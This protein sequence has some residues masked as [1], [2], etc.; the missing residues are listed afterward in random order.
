VTTAPAPTRPVGRRG[1]GPGLPVPVAVLAWLGVAFLA[2][3]FV[4]ML[5]RTP[6]P[7]LV[8][9]LVQ[10]EVAQALRLS[11]VASVA[12]L[13]V[14][15]ALGLPLAWLFARTEFP[16][17]RLVRA[18]CVLP[19][20]LPP[21]VGGVALLLAFGRR[22]VV[23][24][25]LDALTGLTL[26]FTTAG[27]VMAATF[28][29]MPFL[30]VAVE[31]GLKGIDPELERAAATLGADRWT[32]FRR[33]TLPLAAPAVRAGMAVCWARALGEFGATITFAGSL[34]G[35][36]QTLPL[37][38]FLQLET[39]RD[40]AIVSSLLLLAVSVAVLVAL[41]ERYLGVG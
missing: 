4:A 8:E 16:G 28:V 22:G 31:A 39:D 14:G 30:V 7:R 24:Q 5:V 3:P 21:I 13:A 23:G 17:K 2:T 37:A 10:P 35:R 27:V 32:V 12:S 29:A 26:P 40:A 15:C 1:G 11:L 36:T 41:R 18:V 34:P 33:V 19:M 20:V 9:I 6:W 25:P 38:I